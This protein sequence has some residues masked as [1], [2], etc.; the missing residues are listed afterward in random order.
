MADFFPLIDRAVLDLG[1]PTAE[2]RAIVYARA[3]TALGR[4]DRA[5]GE[6][7][8]RDAA[9]LDDAIA[10]VEAKFAD[11]LAQALAFEAAPGDMAPAGDLAAPVPA[12]APPSRRQFAFNAAASGAV[13]I[14]KTLLQLALCPLWRGC[15]APPPTA[16][17]HWPSRP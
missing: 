3:R 9:A 1:E 8:G 16:S 5:R 4:H 13:S 12:A 10:R 11:P 17:T 6:D 14:F 7:A 15:S 2:N